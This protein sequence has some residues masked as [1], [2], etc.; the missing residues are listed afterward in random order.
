MPELP[1]VETV[2][3]TLKNFIIGKEI[4]EISV[5]YDKIIVGDAKIFEKSL[6]GQTIQDIDR[7]GKYLIFILDSDAFI[8]HLRMEGK[9]NIVEASKPLNKHEHIT[10]YFSDGTELRYQ[11]TRKFGRLELANKE[12]YDQD[13]PLCKLGPEPWEADPKDIYSKIHKSS[14]PIKTLLLD[15]SIMTGIG[16]IYANEICF[17]MKMHPK[18]PGKR[19]SKKRV[20]ELVE[21][22]KE[23]LEKAIARGGTTIHSFDANGITGLFQAQLQVHMQKVCPMC[24]GEVTKEKVC[25]RGTYYCK[26]CQK[27]IG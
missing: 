8:S 10:F 6:K 18:T 19:V 4:R 1:E 20:E 15:Q 24:N 3:R 11:D 21:A 13:L 17:C 16:N 2:R 7:V 5:H 12:T 23:I 9:Y 22:S 26:E 14:L 25:G 27:K